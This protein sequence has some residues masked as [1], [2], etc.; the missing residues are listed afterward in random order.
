[1]AAGVGLISLVNLIF[2]YYPEVPVLLVIAGLCLGLLM[3]WKET[4]EMREMDFGGNVKALKFYVYLFVLFVFVLAI[5]GYIEF[6]SLI[7]GQPSKEVYSSLTFNW[8]WVIVLLVHLAA[9]DTSAKMII[10]DAL[11]NTKMQKA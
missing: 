4:K 9:W 2:Q 5:F 1:M 3:W 6:F 8:K 10:K 7:F 11:L